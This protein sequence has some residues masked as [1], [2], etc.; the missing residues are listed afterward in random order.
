M[1]AEKNKEGNDTGKLAETEDNT[2]MTTE[3]RVR[4]KELIA[5]HPKIGAIM[6]P[7]MLEC[8]VEM[9]I[10]TPQQERAIVEKTLTRWSEEE[11]E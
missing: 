10:I 11:G 2:A 3:K 1:E 7:T 6:L 9:S 5:K 4:L 8:L